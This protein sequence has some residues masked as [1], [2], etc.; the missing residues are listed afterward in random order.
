MSIMESIKNR[1]ILFDGAMGTM[2]Q[3]FGLKPGQLPEQMNITDEQTIVRI[4]SMYLEA[5][6]DVITAN[7]FGAN[8]RK[9]KK[10][11]LAQNDVISAALRN[12]R[13]AL[14]LSKSEAYLAYDTGSIGMM[15]EPLGTISF[16]DTYELFKPQ[17]ILAQ[18]HGA[19][20]VLIE[21]MTDIAEMR[22]AL[23]AFK[24]N[25]SLPVICS[26]SFDENKRT[27]TGTDPETMVHILQGLGADAIGVNCSLGPAEFYPMLEII[28]KVC[29]VPVIVQP[30]AGLPIF[31]NGVTGYS[32]G[33]DEFTFHIERLVDLGATIIGGCCGTDPQ[34]IASMRRLLDKKTFK[35]PTVEYR[36]VACSASK[37]VYMDKG[38]TIIGE[39][40]NPT[41]NKPL[42]QAL[43]EG[44]LD[45]A[46]TEA[47]EQKRHGAHIIDVNVSIPG[48]DEVTTMKK[49]A[50]ELSYLVNLPLQFDSVN[51]QAIEQALRIYPGKAII[52]SVSGKKD[53]LEAILP[54]AK[55]YG[56]LLVC[57]CM[58]DDGIPHKHEERVKIAESIM[59]HAD[60]YGID[61]QDLLV[62]CLVLT[63]SAQQKEVLETL[64]AITLLKTKHNAKT[65]LG[66]SNVS[67][68][69]PA[70]ANLNA[71]FL[72][73]ALYAGLD[74]AIIDPSSSLYMDTIRAFRVL[75]SED[76][77]ADSYIKHYGNTAQT[78]A[79]QQNNA[80]GARSVTSLILDGDKNGIRRFVQALSQDTDSVA[81]IEEHIVPSLKAI[82]ELYEAKKIFLP[83]L[84]RSAE[85]SAVAFEEVR[86]MLSDKSETMPH[87]GTIALATVKGDVHDIG[88]NLVKVVLESYGYNVVDLGKDTDPKIISDTVLKK[89]IK[90]VGL[91]ALMTTTLPGMEQTIKLLRKTSPDCVIMVG[92]AVLTEQYAKSIGADYYCQNAL[93]GVKVADSVFS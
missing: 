39:R 69:L 38:V 40:I 81:I 26:M 80:Q 63:A 7:T 21:T 55:K 54:I 42:R 30:N 71:T 41:G 85:T 51:P 52:N 72:A 66:A 37:T 79:T 19:D 14:T 75:S 58:D 44:D 6:A 15:L 35:R 45:R 28:T 68:G 32:C 25:C 46:V 49:L 87:K 34:Y 18:Q 48:I 12:A 70:R 5:G 83:Q 10:A 90:L 82:G 59:T 47:M 77:N 4:H 56:A 64:K 9:L 29:R 73:M 84:I 31:N 3:R 62:D 91:S 67:Y 1:F 61:R 27:L 20:V 86:L 60:E 13:K 11:G 2:L 74:A 33:V 53:S 65:I 23:I 24:E 93:S 22:A 76:E 88:K 92:G 36:A 17:A 8:S 50:L 43:K 78:S 16:E 57:L 89:N